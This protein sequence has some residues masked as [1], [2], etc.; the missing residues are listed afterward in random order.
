MIYFLTISKQKYYKERKKA[1]FT[2]NPSQKHNS[3]VTEQVKRSSVYQE[4]WESNCMFI[5]K[6]NRLFS[7]A[8]GQVHNAKSFTCIISF[9]PENYLAQ[10]GSSTFYRW[11]NWG[12]Y[13]VRHLPK[14]AWKIKWQVFKPVETSVS[15]QHCFASKDHY[16]RPVPQG[17]QC[18]DKK[19]CCLEMHT[20]SLY[21]I[22]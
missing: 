4:T 11:R 13:R 19:A 18:L 5:S 20:G 10:E 21:A 16:A 14:D 17:V 2:M 15:C 6:D 9:N 7:K 8:T 1:W 22:N 12:F 3:G